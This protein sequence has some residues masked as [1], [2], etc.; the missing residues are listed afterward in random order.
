M[1]CE[2]CHLRL[3][4]G[5]VCTGFELCDDVERSVAPICFFLWRQREWNPQIRR[6][7][8][9]HAFAHHAD[10]RERPSVDADTLAKD[11]RVGAEVALP[12]AVAQDDNLI[13]ASLIFAGGKCPAQGGFD[14]EG[15]KKVSG[16][17]G[18]VNALRFSGARQ[19][20]IAGSVGRDVL[21]RMTLRLPVKIIGWSNGALL[22]IGK[23]HNSI[24]RRQGKWMNEESLGDAEDGSVDPDAERQC[25]HDGSREARVLPKHARAKAQVLQKNFQK[26]QAAALAVIFFRLFD[27]AEFHDGLPPRLS[28]RHAHTQIVFD[29]Q[30]EVALHLGGQLALAAFLAEKS[31]YAQKPRTCASHGQSFRSKLQTSKFGF[32]SSNHSYRNAMI[33]STDAARRAGIALA[34]TATSITP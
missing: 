23:S 31:G 6:N 5:E 29:V 4:L 28:R 1:A 25:D 34:M 16:D 12:Q 7:W 18:S 8:E 11:S 14:T 33:G 13:A 15:G 24:E 22:P 9:L 17:C 32:I 3:C 20:H 19:I 10:D 21:E 26:R 27:A 30:L 2:K